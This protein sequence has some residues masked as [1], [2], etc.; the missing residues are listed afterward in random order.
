[1]MG[2]T[3]AWNT[4]VLRKL[5]VKVQRSCYAP[6][7]FLAFGG[8]AAPFDTSAQLNKLLAHNIFGQVLEYPV[9]DKA[10]Y[11]E[12]IQLFSRYYRIVKTGKFDL[13]RD[14]GLTRRS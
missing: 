12:G 6:E 2:V 11:D 8:V 14:W 3:L 9:A 1:M 4:I 5:Q 10:V 7:N 13:P